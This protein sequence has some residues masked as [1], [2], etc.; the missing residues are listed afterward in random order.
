METKIAPFPDLRGLGNEFARAGS[1]WYRRCH[2]TG[3]AYAPARTMVNA[4]SVPGSLTGY[5]VAGSSE[6]G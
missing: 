3:G 1:W 5:S 6:A 2:W 4:A